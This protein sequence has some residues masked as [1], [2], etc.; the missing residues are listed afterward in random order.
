MTTGHGCNNQRG[1]HA[2]VDRGQ[3]VTGESVPEAYGEIPNRCRGDAAG[4]VNVGDV[5]CG[6]EAILAKR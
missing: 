1:F 4:V 6:M 3:S 5:D 2:N